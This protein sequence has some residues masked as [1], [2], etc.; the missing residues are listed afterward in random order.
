MYSIVQRGAGL[1]FLYWEVISE[2][3]LL[4]DIWPS[5]HNKISL[6]PYAREETVTRIF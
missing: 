2:D 6:R 3:H 1:R 4:Y 5:F